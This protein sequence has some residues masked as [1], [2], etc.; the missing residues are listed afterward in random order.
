MNKTEKK[1]KRKKKKK[2]K[3]KKKK[4]ED[5]QRIL[6]HKLRTLLCVYNYHNQFNSS[7]FS[8]C[9]CATYSLSVSCLSNS[10]ML[11]TH[12]VCFVCTPLR[13]Q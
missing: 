5:R 12:P 11:C 9:A 13:L 4:K 7:L 2:K 3:T 10:S 1:K 8:P 6:T